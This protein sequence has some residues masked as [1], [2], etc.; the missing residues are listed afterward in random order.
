M[1]HSGC[2]QAQICSTCNENFVGTLDQHIRQ[3]RSTKLETENAGK[4][5][6]CSICGRGFKFERN[7]LKHIES[8]QQQYFCDICK[9]GRDYKMKQRLKKHKDNVHGKGPKQQRQSVEDAQLEYVRE[10]KKEKVKKVRVTSKGVESNPPSTLVCT[11]CSKE[12]STRKQL[13]G[14]MRR[15][16][17]SEECSIC[18]KSYHQLNRHM[19]SHRNLKEHV[20]H[21]C[22]SAYAQAASLTEHIE[23]KHLPDEE[24]YCDLC[25]NGKKY[26]S[27]AYLKRHLNNV[28]AKA[29]TS[30]VKKNGCFKCRICSEEFPSY[31]SLNRHN[32][33]RHKGGKVH[34][35]CEVCD[36][37][38]TTKW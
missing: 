32:S 8:H 26:P 28:H 7:L 9:D 18:G 33:L 34:F 14:H 15:H 3:C 23:T 35:Q 38:F 20:C 12:C 5:F 31:Y 16:E 27:R 25:Q 37:T 21:I 36:K 30:S 13:A 6:D 2:H 29:R 22:G 24:F 4:S 1:E 10:A 11:V 19:D 17:K